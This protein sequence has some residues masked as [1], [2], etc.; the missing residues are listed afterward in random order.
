MP[1]FFYL[2]EEDKGNAQPLDED[3]WF[4]KNQ[5][6]LLAMANT[7]FGRELLLIPEDYPRIVLFKKNCVH[8]YNDN[9]TFGADFRIGAKWANV[10]RI[11]WKEF[12]SYAR[13]FQSY[14]PYEYKLSPATRNMLALTAATLTVYPDP[15][16][17]TTSVD[18]RTNNEINGTYAT[19]HDAASS[20]GAGDTNLYLDIWNSHDASSNYNVVR[21]MMLYDT[22]SLTA[23]A[24]ISSAVCT[25]TGYSAGFIVETGGTDSLTIVT[26][27]PASNTAVTTADFDQYGTTLQATAVAFSSLSDTGANN[28]TLNATGLSNISKT[29][30]TKFGIRTQ[31]DVDNTDAAGNGDVYAFFKSADTADVTS[32]PK[33]V[34]TY[35]LP[36][37]G[38]ATGL[39]LLGI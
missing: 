19:A 30:I 23:S 17:E 38:G 11:R 5:K 7:K 26:T 20:S 21:S 25:L 28:I 14:N 1:K 33:L 29:S 34:V 4:I 12:N 13:Y 31:K 36:A 18:G 16:A 32:D 35:T 2:R 8:W 9:G 3:V 6:L 22:S 37:A 10:I 27:T 39:T 24:T 15:N